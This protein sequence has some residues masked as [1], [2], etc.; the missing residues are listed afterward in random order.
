LQRY[1]L[2]HSY[3]EFL[4]MS[5]RSFLKIHEATNSRTCKVI[6]RRHSLGLFNWPR[7]FTPTSEIQF[8]HQVLTLIHHK[9]PPRRTV[10]NPVNAT[11]VTVRDQWRR[12]VEKW[13]SGSAA[14]NGGWR[15][16]F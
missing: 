2:Q 11:S 5:E 10:T 1:P 3:Y 16:T 13:R 6:I 12:R 4:M 15:G 14:L 8:L 7:A 9:H